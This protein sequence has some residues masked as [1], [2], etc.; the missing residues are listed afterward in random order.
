MNTSNIILLA[1]VIGVILIDMIIR[2]QNGALVFKTRGSRTYVLLMTLLII[3]LTPILIFALEYVTNPTD[4]IEFYAS[5]K[6]EYSKL[7]IALY[8]LIGGFIS[9]ILFRKTETY[10]SLFEEIKNK[11]K[12]IFL[13][14]CSVLISKVFIH[15]SLFPKIVGSGDSY[16][17]LSIDEYSEVRKIDHALGL[18][19]GDYYPFRHYIKNVFQEEISLFLPS[20]IIVVV[21]YWLI[22]EI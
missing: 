10:K 21:V 22:R 18:T 8:A 17:G 1:I 5:Q 12:R 6:L 14:F 4:P 19:D 16:V 20:F 11:P 7:W 13:A 3:L 15:Y 2:R 9:A